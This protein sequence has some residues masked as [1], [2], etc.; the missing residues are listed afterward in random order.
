MKEYFSSYGDV[1]IVELED[2]EPCNDGNESEVLK[3][4][5]AHVS[6]T[7]RHSAERAFLN[8]KCW[9]GNNLTFLWV[10][11]SNSGNDPGGR[12]NSSAP[13]CPVD[14]DVQPVEKLP[15]MDSLEA[16]ASGN[17][18][19]NSERDG[20]VN[21]AELQE[22]SQPCSA[23]ISC[24]KESPKHGPSSTSMSIEE[25]SLKRE[26]SPTSMSGEKESPKGAC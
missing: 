2:A 9:E 17:E 19:E 12:E 23:S 8:G 20:G 11:S 24:E 21:H 15:R 4:C 7:S 6:F 14:D 16:S 26:P 18:P 3:N 22:V 5:S 25:E 13:K 1:S 10:T